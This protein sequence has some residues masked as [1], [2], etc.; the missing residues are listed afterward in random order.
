M[1]VSPFVWHFCGLPDP[2]VPRSRVHDLL[3]MLVIA[4][5]AMLSGAE[6]WEEIARFGRIRQAWLKERLGLRLSAG[7][8]TD[9]TFRRVF[10]RLDARAF[11]ACFQEWAATL[12]LS[13]KDE[14][15]A[16]DGKVLRH[17]FDTSVDQSPINLVRAWSCQQRLVLGVMP[18]AQGTNEIP[19]LQALLKL[20]DLRGCLISAD[21]AHCQKETATLILKAEADYLLSVKGN[22]PTLRA[23]IENLFARLERHPAAMRDWKQAVDGRSFS[24]YSSNNH[25]HAR[26]ESR[27]ACV[28]GLAQRDQDWHDV[29]AEWPGLRTLVKVRRQRLENGKESNETVYY[30]SSR[31]ADAM[32]MAASIRRHWQ[33]ENSLHWVLD[34]GL[35]EDR[36]RISDPNAAANLATIRCAAINL[37]RRQQNAEGG[38]R[39]RIKRAGWEPDYLLTLLTG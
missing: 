4:F 18:V 30:I 32:Q 24:S 7:V 9:D 28:L 1:S 6:G 2:R 35:D 15:I 8:P 16:L 11:A 3:E 36:C 12:R 5:L 13:Q 39:A 34:C 37:V 25:A 38:V 17:S 27:S 22:Q 14:H 23:D 31:T 26:Q 21:A 20:L 33:I 10:S 29:Q 19:T